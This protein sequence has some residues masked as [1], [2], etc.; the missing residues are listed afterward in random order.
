MIT[1]PYTFVAT[2]H[3]LLWNG[4]KPV[5]V[6]VKPDSFT[7][8]PEKIEGAI[9][10]QTTAILPVHCYGSPCD[11]ERIEEIA[12]VYGLRVLYDAAHAFGVRYK[13]RSILTYGDLSVLSFHATKVQSFVRTEKPSSVS[14][15]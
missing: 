7:L 3:A 11:V 9:T 13:G 1:T 8:D 4:I 6:D 12:D 2:S 10:S 5:F 14:T 15:T